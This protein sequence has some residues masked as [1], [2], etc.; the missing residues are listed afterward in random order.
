MDLA[1]LRVIRS[2]LAPFGDEAA[3]FDHAWGERARMW[4]VE[5]RPN[6]DSSASFSAAFDGDDLVTMVVGQTSC[7]VFPVK[8]VDDLDAV[9][10]IAEAVFEGKLEEAEQG[11]FARMTMRDGRVLAVGSLHLPIPWRLRRRP[12]YAPYGPLTMRA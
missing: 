1:L 4:F 11:G 5:A 12:T 6:N 8:H 10:E 9:R 7:E 2:A 3:T